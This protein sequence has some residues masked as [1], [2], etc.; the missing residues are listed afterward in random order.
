M[1][2]V[3]FTLGYLAEILFLRSN[4]LGVSASSELTAEKMVNFLKATLAVEVTYYVAMGFIKTS[5]LLLYL[6]FGMY[7]L[8]PGIQTNR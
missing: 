6:R 7:I 4:G 1:A 3:V 5:I 2:A 8:C